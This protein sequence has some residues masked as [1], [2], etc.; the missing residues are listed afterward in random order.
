[1]GLEDKGEGSGWWS[2]GE[3]CS[4]LWAMQLWRTKFEGKRRDDKG[5]G[6]VEN[7]EGPLFL[8]EPAIYSSYLLLF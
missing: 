4:G 3:R 8:Q 6:E 5:K 7:R 2:G 1:M